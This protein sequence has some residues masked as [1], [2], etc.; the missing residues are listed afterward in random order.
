MVRIVRRFYGV[1]NNWSVVVVVRVAR[2]NCS[3]KSCKRNLRG[4]GGGSFSSVKY[5]VRV[6]RGICR[7]RELY[8]E[9]NGVKEKLI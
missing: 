9:F 4:E 5:S 6:V 8:E 1:R 3:C 7:C 2:K